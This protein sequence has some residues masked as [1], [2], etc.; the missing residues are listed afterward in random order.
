MQNKNYF[1]VFIVERKYLRPKVRG[2]NKREKNNY[3][4]CFSLAYSYLCI[5]YE[6]IIISNAR[7]HSADSMH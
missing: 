4:F 5:H 1:F 3:K 7:S 2:T 6:N